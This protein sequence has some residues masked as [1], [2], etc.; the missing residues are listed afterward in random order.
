VQAGALLIEKQG[1]THKLIVPHLVRLEAAR[2]YIEE[3][4]RRIDA[5]ETPLNTEGAIAKLVATEAGNGAADAAIQALGGY[6]YMREYEVEK[7]RRDVRITTI[8]EGTS[9][10]MEWTIARDRWRDNLQQRGQFYAQLAPEVDALHARAPDVGADIAALA[11]RALHVLIERARVGRLTRNQH[12]LFRL[13]EWIAAVETAAAFARYAAEDRP[14]VV[15]LGEAAVKAMSRVYAREAAALIAS[16]GLRWI[17]G[18]EDGVDLASLET[19][20]GIASIHAAQ[21]GL[22]ADMDLIAQ[23]LRDVT[24][25]D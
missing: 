2:A 1:Y 17:Y 19:S 5:G 24:F 10:I 18:A 7:I 4:A 12:I 16:E 20:M 14:R 3:T 11:M 22:V 9:E 21:R 6:G 23:A 13:G 8:Y 15:P 25:A